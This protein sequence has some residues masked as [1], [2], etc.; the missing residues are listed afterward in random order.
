MATMSTRR[1]NEPTQSPVYKSVLIAMMSYRDAGIEY[2]K[3][4]EFS[5]EELGEVTPGM[6]INGWL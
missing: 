1:V 4:Y 5:P 3:S 6:S 2:S